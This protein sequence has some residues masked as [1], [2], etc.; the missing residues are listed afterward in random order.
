[1]SSKFPEV[2][3]RLFTNVYVCRKCK[4]KMLST[5]K[6]VLTKSLRC[7]NCGGK[8]FRPIKKAKAVAK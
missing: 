5:P 7:R 3:R 2:M 4:R 1:M 6:K 8:A